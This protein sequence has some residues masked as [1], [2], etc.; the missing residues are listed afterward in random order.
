MLVLL[1]LNTDGQYIENA[2]TV[3]VQCSRIRKVNS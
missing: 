2:R 1:H 3:S